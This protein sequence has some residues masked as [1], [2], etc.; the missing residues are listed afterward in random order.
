MVYEFQI[1]AKDR[2]KRIQLI[3]KGR[4]D[5]S[6]A[7]EELIEEIESAMVHVIHDDAEHWE[8]KGISVIALYSPFWNYDRI[9]TKLYRV[10]SK[11]VLSDE[12]LNILNSDDEMTYLDID[13]VVLLQDKPE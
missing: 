2:F 6:E 12:L 13:R 1:I 4:N 11:R 10:L 8:K 9:V 5:L 7:P 3:S